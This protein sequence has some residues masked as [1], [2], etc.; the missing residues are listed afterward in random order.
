MVYYF[1][2]LFAGINHF[3]PASGSVRLADGV[4]VAAGPSYIGLSYSSFTR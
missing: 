4:A 3:T 1:V 2:E